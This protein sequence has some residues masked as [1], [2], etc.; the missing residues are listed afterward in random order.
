MTKNIIITTIS[1]GVIVWQAIPEGS[2]FLHESENEGITWL[3]GWYT[4]AC[5]S[6]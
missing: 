2:P 3:R 1:N 6:G 4:K 5:L